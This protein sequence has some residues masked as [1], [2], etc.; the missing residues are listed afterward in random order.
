MFKYILPNKKS[1]VLEFETLYQIRLPESYR[2]FCL[3]N[4]NLKTK[5]AYYPLYPLKDTTK[6]AWLGFIDNYALI[7]DYLRE[8]CRIYPQMGETEWAKWNT[9]QLI[10]EYDD[11]EFFAL[12][13]Q[14]L[15]GLLP[16]GT[17][18]STIEIALILN[19]KYAGQVVFFDCEYP[20]YYPDFKGDF[21]DWYS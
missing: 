13:K 18:G 20:Q 4:K 17:E 2:E 16:I 15:G 1:S 11:N 8:P 5:N 7:S 14:R 9:Y 3:Q 12:Q 21:S 19:G 6:R 10:D